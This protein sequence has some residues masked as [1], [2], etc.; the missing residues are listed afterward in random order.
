MHV[1]ALLSISQLTRLEML[2]FIHSKDVIGAK[3][4]I[5]M[6]HT[7]FRNIYWSNICHSQHAYQI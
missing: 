1:L 7:P 5:K 2:S 3:I 6:G 4:N